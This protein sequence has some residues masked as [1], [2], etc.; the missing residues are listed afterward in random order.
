MHKHK[1]IQPTSSPP[2]SASL[3]DYNVAPGSCDSALSQLREEIKKVMLPL[4]IQ[5]SLN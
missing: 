4:L 1:H 2:S 3:S 5:V